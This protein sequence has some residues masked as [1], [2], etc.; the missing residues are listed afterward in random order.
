[1]EHPNSIPEIDA[2]A[3]KFKAS[4][5]RRKSAQETELAARDHLIDL[6]KQHKLEVYEDKDAGLLVSMSNHE[7]VRVEDTNESKLKVAEDDGEDA[8]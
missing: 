7:K 3:E 1:M 4:S 8:A 6:M 5:K 2:A